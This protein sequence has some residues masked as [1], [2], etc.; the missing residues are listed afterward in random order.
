MSSR[1]LEILCYCNISVNI[2]L[3]LN[4]THVLN[5]TS[6][7]VFKITSSCDSGIEFESYQACHQKKETNGNNKNGDM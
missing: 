5:K 6:I 1:Y 2:L 3:F 7:N 4:K